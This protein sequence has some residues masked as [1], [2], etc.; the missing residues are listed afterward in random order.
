MLNL[1]IVLLD[2]KMDGNNGLPVVASHLMHS[3]DARA[4]FIINTVFGLPASMCVLWL[5]LAGPG[6]KAAKKS[7]SLNQAVFEVVICTANAFALIAVNSR[8]SNVA[9]STYPWCVRFVFSWHPLFT[10]CDFLKRSRVS[11]A[12]STEQLT[13]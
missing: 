8:T 4:P 1:F 7:F 12:V 9:D 10:S 6:G 13:I 2:G 3:A 11:C 5:I